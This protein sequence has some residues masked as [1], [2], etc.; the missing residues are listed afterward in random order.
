[1]EL[2][3]GTL[4]GGGG[5]VYV[6]TA[7]RWGNAVSL[8]QSNYQGFGSGLVDPATGIAFHDRGAFFRLDPQHPNALASGKRPTH[9]LAPGML[10]RGGRPWVVHGS[11]GG[12]IQP[13]VF[14]QVVSALVDG[15]ADV[16]TAVAAP[17]WAAMMQ[18]QHGPADLT[19]L[20]C[21]IHDEV[22]EALRAK[23]HEVTV[24]EPWASSMGHAHALEIVRDE[25]G[26][27]VSY[28]AA[29]DP[30]AEGSAAAW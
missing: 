18:R 21:R 24:R 2:R 12:E 10:L 27:V 28:A 30:R 11:M 1:M 8:L 14:S 17:R 4:P 15:E 3:P 25:A 19:E 20:E 16:A 5:T 29:S 9:T 26:E 6:A 7:D 22:P 23:G 13:Q